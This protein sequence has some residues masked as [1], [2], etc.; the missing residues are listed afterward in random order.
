[1]PKYTTI[2]EKVVDALMDSELRYR[3]LF[4]TAKDGILILDADTGFITDV[5]PFLVELLGYSREQFLNKEIWAIGFFKDIVAN[6]DKFHELQ[7]NKYVRYDDLPLKTSE[8]NSISVEFVSNVYLVNHRKVIQC[9]IR[10]ITE[11]KL[12]AAALQ[13]SKDYLDKIINAVAAPI[14]VK[15]SQYKFCLVNDSFCS[16][17]NVPR[18]S[19]IGY[20]DHDFF[21]EEQ[22]RVFIEKDKEVFA[23]GKG[24]INEELLTDG[25]GVLRT[26]VTRKTMYTDSSGN[27][28]LVGVINDIT[29]RKVTE[30]ALSESEQRFRTIFEHASIGVALIN[31]KTGEIVRINQKYC[32]FIGYSVDEMLQK[33]YMDI[34]YL[35][36]IQLNVA[37]NAKVLTGEEIEYSIEKRFVRKDGALVWGKLTVSPLWKPGEK[38]DKYFH[39]AMVEDITERKLKEEIILKLNT[40]LEGRV[41][42]RTM[43]LEIVNKELESFSFSVSHDLRAPLRRIHGFIQI[44]LEDYAPKFDEAGEELCASIMSNTLKMDMLIENLLS[45]AQIGRTDLQKSEINMNNMVN[46]VYQDVTDDLSRK[47]IHLVIGPLAEVKADASMM[48]HVWTNLLSNAI[49]YSS[50]KQTSD[51]SIACTKNSINYTFSIKDNGVGFDMAYVSKIF[52]VFQRLHTTEEF[53]G[54]GVGLAIVKR[55]VERHGGT[56]W[57]EGAVDHG[58]EVFFTLPIVS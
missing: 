49:K 36:D 6:K 4:E 41:H 19:L 21:P 17:I 28:F 9:N 56:V 32:D 33:T 57:A 48:R 8:G 16:L 20:S 42:E 14:F 40:S 29:E 52:G 38:P 25:N 51:I 55:I 26:I 13:E 18:S 30:N 53:L 15:D 1:M 27:K 3:R 7:Q 39:I 12:A 46:D 11:R 24:N 45:F 34:T 43:Q 2:N 22:S 35:E 5:N 58:A 47:R 37:K 10:N 50:K 31:T 23:T 54:T 44:L